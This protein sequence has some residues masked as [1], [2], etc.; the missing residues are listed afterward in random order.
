M[1]KISLIMIVIIIFLLTACEADVDLTDTLNDVLDTNDTSE[2]YT[3]DEI[4]VE[5]DSKM[6]KIQQG[7]FEFNETYMDY[8]LSEY[9][10]LS[11]DNDAYTINEGGVYVLEG[12][13]T[14]TITI[15][16]NDEDVDLVLVNATIS[17]NSGPAVLVLSGDEITISAA[18][19]TENLIED[20]YNHTIVNNEDY[21]AAIY[22]KSDLVFNGTG[23]L[24]VRG[25]YND[26][27]TSKDDIKIVDL[28]LD[29]TS[30]DDGIVGKDYIAVSNAT[31]T[32]DSFGDSM[33]S[34]NEEDS[35][36]GFIYIESGT[37]DLKSVTDAIQAVNSILI[38]DGTFT[39]ESFDDGITSDASIIIGGGTFNIDSND[40]AFNAS[41][42]L[43]IYDGDLTISA[44]DDALH[45]YDHVLIEGATI[46]IIKSYEGIESYV[47]EIN[48][49][50]INVVSSDDAINAT[51]GGGQEHG[52]QYVATG[53]TITINGGII[54]INSAGD[55]ID[56]NGDVI[57]T[58]GYLVVYGPLTD[59]ES[60]IDFDGTFSISGGLV[61][62]IGS[63]G[64]LQSLSTTS[65]QAS[66]VYAN[67]DTYS[68]G[69][70]VALK[71]SD[72][73]VII[74]IDAI[75]SFEAVVISS[76]EMVT[77]SSYS[78]EIGDESIDFTISSILTSLGS[79]ASSNQQG[80]RP[81]P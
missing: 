39:I 76:E 21:S 43:I 4:D 80:G 7:E 10:V 54:Q 5:L 33:K 72:G 71:D 67:S 52:P 59:M 49:G 64:M 57:M 77:G 74:Q 13:Y 69:T 36:K 18:P 47:V 81:R 40:D 12:K 53:G 41:K 29:I 58:G 24:T 6:Y 61:I 44:E 78:L 46:N 8:N 3:D 42:E 45:G 26:A 56:A 28:V 60:T 63:D 27:I 32:I 31:I 68:A 62:A 38:Y 50:T 79:G 1:K 11:A 25:A 70:T 73:N 51:V 19:N 34:T 16:A 15:D 23:N 14:S 30:V 66:L 37:F 22:S 20:S 2:E 65:T 35:S 9:T 75:K 55:G 48:G 17:T